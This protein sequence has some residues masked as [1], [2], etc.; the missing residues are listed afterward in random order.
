MN[1]AKLPE[2]QDIIYCAAR[3]NTEKQEKYGVIWARGIIL[4]RY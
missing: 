3:E 2:M 1:F 4:G